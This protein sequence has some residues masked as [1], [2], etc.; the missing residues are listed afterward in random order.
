MN[1]RK[2]KQTQSKN[3]QTKTN[4]QEIKEIFKKLKIPL[5]HFKIKHI[6]SKCVTIK[7][8]LE[9]LSENDCEEYTSKLYE[10]ARLF[11]NPKN[12][13]ELNKQIKHAETTYKNLLNKCKTQQSQ[14][15]SKDVYI[16]NLEENQR[17]NVVS[18]LK[19]HKNVLKQLHLMKQASNEN[20]HLHLEPITLKLYDYSIK[21]FIRNN[22]QQIS[23]MI[24]LKTNH[25]Q[26]IDIIKNETITK[27]NLKTLV[28]TINH[29]LRFFKNDTT[30]ND[31]IKNYKDLLVPV[32]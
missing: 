10:H 25:K 24:E 14:N 22:Y 21:K 27:S 30:K 17:N 4:I 28:S 26:I 20:A 8:G 3:Q 16:A 7:N 15:N 23:D 9:K 6:L 32:P 18:E 5:R 12:D 19:I 11:A 29:Y 2:G 1:L 31:A 13:K